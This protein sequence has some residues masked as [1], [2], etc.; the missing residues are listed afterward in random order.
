[1]HPFVHG[2][3][4]MMPSSIHARHKMQRRPTSAF[5]PAALIPQPPLLQLPQSF[6][7][8]L[9]YHA[10]QPC[11]EQVSWALRHKGRCSA[12]AATVAAQRAEGW[13][14]VGCAPVEVDD[15][16]LPCVVASCQAAAVRA[17]GQAVDFVAADA[18]GQ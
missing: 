1:M 13:L 18:K 5:P 16:A 8:P 4:L 11:G 10:V 7:I 9:G 2:Y 3:D 14:S 15:L 12:Y 6:T 17:E